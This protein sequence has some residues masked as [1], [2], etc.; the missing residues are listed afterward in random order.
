[1]T[2]SPLTVPPCH[3][4]PSVQSSRQRLYTCTGVLCS[5]LLASPSQSVSSGAPM[6]LLSV[7]RIGVYEMCLD[8]KEPLL[9]PANTMTPLSSV[10]PYAYRSV[11]E[12]GCLPGFSLSGIRRAVCDPGGRWSS[13]PP[14]CAGWLHYTYALRLTARFSEGMCG[15]GI[16]AWIHQETRSQKSAN[17]VGM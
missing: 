12:F 5:S 14:L 6:I 9:T 3:R 10:Q 11:V 15:A 2:L 7:L 16:G 13:P 4:A 1:M 8:C 17:S